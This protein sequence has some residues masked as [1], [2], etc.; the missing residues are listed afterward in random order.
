[1]DKLEGKWW[2]PPH[3]LRERTTGA[4]KLTKK[5]A[6]LLGQHGSCS[7]EGCYRAVALRE[8][9]LRHSNAE[10]LRVGYKMPL[11][12]MNSSSYGKDLSML[13][14]EDYTVGRRVMFKHA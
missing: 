12:G 2:R 7:R 10:P 11:G 1:M 14:Q 13:G 3:V 5:S 4:R 9:R 6:L 8:R